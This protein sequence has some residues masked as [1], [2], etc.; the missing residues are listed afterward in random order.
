MGVHKFAPIL[1]HVGD[2]G[3]VSNRGRWKLNI[4]R[5]W[6]RLV[7]MDN[8]RLTKRVFSWDREQHALTNKS[9]F[10]SQA[11]QILI[12]LER[13]NCYTNLGT[14]NITDM[15]SIVYE[16]DKSNWSNGVKDKPKLDF[17]SDIK[18]EMGVEPFVK[19]N[20]SKYERSLLAQWRYGILQIRLETG[21]Y[22][23][24]KREDRLCK[25][26]NEGVVEDQN[27]FIWHCSKY[28]EI[29][30]KFVQLIKNSH[31]GWDN[32]TEN[33]KFVFLFKEKPR[34]LARY[35]KDLFL[36]RKGVIYR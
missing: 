9:N 17:L 1:G 31:A 15:K 27:H 5:L 2:M 32:L 12:E 11:R 34:A 10:S 25:V 36:H 22:C 26:C 23:N 3:W 24:E 8:D 19:I 35:V 30:D 13:N 28:N 29:R 14:V 6:N 21:R 20:I 7:E 16:H 18:T 4:L 33:D